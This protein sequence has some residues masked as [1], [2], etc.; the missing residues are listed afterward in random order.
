MSLYI[1]KTVSGNNT[2]HITSSSTS[3]S[4]MKS[5]TPLINTVFHS[6]V[7]MLTA[8]VFNA[9]SISV[10]PDYY[11]LFTEA[12]IA[13]IFSN[14]ERRVYELIVNGKV[15][16]YRTWA[17]NPDTNIFWYNLSKTVYNNGIF[18][19][20]RYA[21]IKNSVPITSVQLVVYNIG[22]N[23]TWLDFIGHGNILIN[24]TTIRINNQNIAEI[25]YVIN[26]VNNAIDYSFIDD[27]AITRQIVNSVNG[28]GVT[29]SSSPTTTQ[30]KVGSKVIIN[31][32]TQVSVFTKHAVQTTYRAYNSIL[33]YGNSTDNHK[34]FDIPSNAKE[35]LC[36]WLFTGSGGVDLTFLIP[37][38]SGSTVLTAVYQGGVSTIYIYL[39]ILNNVLYV[40]GVGSGNNADVLHFLEA[41]YYLNVLSYLN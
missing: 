14:A 28:V 32:S 21:R 8:K 13:Y 10:G 7:E 18:A 31:S 4:S 2:L 16:R 5:D 1:G 41:N 36:T 17:N 40:R 19:T 29:L 30:I 37:N 9:A 33:F 22:I 20:A 12:T 35:L 26:G 11:I 15:H 25:G 38:I 23:G 24:D 39:Y 3:S 34:L 27:G 6:S